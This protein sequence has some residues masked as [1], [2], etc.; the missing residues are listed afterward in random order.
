MMATKSVLITGA[1][2]GIGLATAHELHKRG[3]LV[4]AGYLPGED[5]TALKS[6]TSE[7]LM[8]IAID[9][10][11]ADSI[12]AAAEAISRTAGGEGLYGLVN[13]AGIAIAGPMEFMPLDALRTQ[14]EVNFMGQVA[15]TQ[16]FLPLVRRAKGRV[17]N[18]CSIL[19]RVV[20]PFSG[21]YCAS[22]FAM[23]A[24]TDALRMELKPHNVKVIGI[25]PGLIRT[26]IWQKTLETMEE[27]DAELPPAGRE[28]YGKAFKTMQSAVSRAGL[29]C[30]PP[31]AVAAA[32]AQ[33]LT[34]AR[35]KTR[36]L[37]GKEARLIA[38][39]RWLL[40]DSWLDA[41]IY[42]RYRV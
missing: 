26:P 27:I 16:A 19:G 32:I 14:F 39:A 6:G 29:E 31:E 25:E 20:S 13:N 17:V 4:F 28:L 38:R 15:V 3:F 12:Q 34:A 37:V 2:S 41:L 24:F 8:P 35:P 21:P 9:V 36:Y 5:L 23:E 42:R 22:K 30:S 33:A 40:P 10:T 7:R 1:S 11:K 18:L